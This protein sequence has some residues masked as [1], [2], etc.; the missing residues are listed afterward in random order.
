MRHDSKLDTCWWVLRIGLGS[1][2]FLAGL[3]KFFNLLTNWS[4]YLSPLMERLLPVSGTVFM[5]LIGPVE[6]IVG[7]AI[8]TRWTRLGAYVAAAW[9]LAI[10]VNLLTTGNF[11]DLAVRD[12]EMALAAW[13]LARLTEIRASHPRERTVMA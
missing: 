9:L 3:D 8:L 2:A 1:A 11:Y 6:M 5:R 4:M 13:V 10:A 7:L 12:V